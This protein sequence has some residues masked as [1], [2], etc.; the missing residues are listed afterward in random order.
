MCLVE[1]SIPKIVITSQKFYLL[2]FNR[3]ICRT[4]SYNKTM[5]N[6]Y[7]FKS[8]ISMLLMALLPL[9][10][11]AQIDLVQTSDNSILAAANNVILSCSDGQ[12]TFE[13]SF[14]R[15]YNLNDL[16]YNSFEVTKVTAAISLIGPNE[17][18]VVDISAQVYSTNGG[19]NSA[20]LA[21]VGSATTTVDGQMGGSLVD[22][23][24]T[25]PVTVSSDAMMIVVTA[26]NLIGSGSF[27]YFGGNSNGESAQ[28]FFRSNDS[29][30]G[31]SEF[32]GLS[33]FGMV[34][35]H[36]V[37]FP[38]GYP[39]L[40]CP[41]GNVFLQSQ[42]EVN[43]FGIDYP[44]CTQVTGNL[45]VQVGEG[46]S[47]IVDLSPLGNIVSISGTFQ[48]NNNTFLSDLSGMSNLVEVAG[49]SLF[50]NGF[51]NLD[52][53][54]SLSSC[55][56]GVYI[57]QNNN[58]TN[59]NALSNIISMEAIIID[60]NDVLTDISG[61]ENVEVGTI[62]PGVG[63]TITNNSALAVCNIPNICEYI[64]NDPTTYLRNISGN[65]AEC[66]DEQAVVNACNGPAD[67]CTEALYGQYPSSTFVPS[68]TGAAEVIV[69]DAWTGEY[70][71]VETTE[72]V[73]YTFSSS[74]ATDYITITSE[75][76]SVVLGTFTGSTSA[77]LAP[78]DAVVRFY[79]HENDQCESADINRS[80][81]VQCS[82][83]G[84]EEVVASSFICYPNPTKDLLNISFD[85]EI[86]TVSIFN[87][88]GEV[89][90]N[91][92]VNAKNAQLDIQLLI[93]GNYIVK[94]LSN[95]TVLT[96]SVIK[97]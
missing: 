48:L 33:D 25:T 13:N 61:L 54:S 2:I 92:T 76:G 6:F 97:E 15:L 17:N 37:L 59:V 66:I 72:G 68:C 24:F 87:I 89:V 31:I 91:K 51:T 69:T 3:V 35:A 78:M 46:S 77:G 42:A 12:F 58:L 60:N 9:L 65:L 41:A 14:G 95:E 36:L 94:A 7:S 84:V 86:S 53:F 1:F 44:T 34:D 71:L 93:P 26:P 11:S 88:L 40:T 70:S 16:G 62:I 20:D 32:T 8:K 47:D 38:T 80:R 96:T 49:L 85:R 45:Y 67:G 10:S 22:I 64:A 83:V 43:Q 27:L 82:I 73:E 21:L 90:M 81:I 23:V 52:G 57:S 79:L 63:I 74:V 19:T 29:E 50:N 5:T 55:Q 30:C 39:T 56:I 4:N 28:A 75:D 18:T